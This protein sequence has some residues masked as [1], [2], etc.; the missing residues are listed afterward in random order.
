[1]EDLY[2]LPVDVVE[3]GSR[4]GTVTFAMLWMRSRYFVQA[5]GVKGG[6]DTGVCG[7]GRRRKIA[8]IE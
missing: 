5:A 8:K 3:K 1:M 6:G 4:K 2:V 7:A